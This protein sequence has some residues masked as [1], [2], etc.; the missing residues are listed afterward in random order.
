MARKKA[1]GGNGGRPI[2]AGRFRG[3]QVHRTE[4]LHD[5]DVVEIRQ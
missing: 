1:T 2:A 4:S 3:R 5:K